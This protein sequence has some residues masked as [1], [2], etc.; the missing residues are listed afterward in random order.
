[1]AGTAET[2]SIS[3]SDIRTDHHGFTLLTLLSEKLVA[4]TAAVEM[5][6]S[7]LNWIDGN[8]CAPLGVVLA[9]GT[10]RMRICNTTGEGVGIMK[11]NGFLQPSGYRKQVDLRGTTIAYTHFKD[12]GI[13][14]SEFRDYVS[15]HF[16]Q[17]EKGLPTMTPA[18]LKR[19]REAL[20]EI[21][22]NALEHSYTERGV[23]ACGQYYPTKQRLDFSIADAGIGFARN[24][25]RNKELTMADNAAIRW[26]LSG[27]TCRRGGRPGGL[28]LKLIQEFIRLNKGRLVVVSDTAYY[29]W[30]PV[31]VKELSLPRRFPG[32]V[33]TI[34]INTADKQ[35]Y[36]LSSEISAQDI[37]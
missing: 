13:G 21:F 16:R 32:S 2:A 22:E 25:E 30:S 15:D 36:C 18:L 20:F 8:M 34:E 31:G 1:M 28:G 19:F 17:E 10:R 5:D 7:Q 9:Q 3:L 23:F 4:A 14:S 37:F 27:N 33:M 26:A 29:E 6:M 35:S 12:I 11:R 24:I